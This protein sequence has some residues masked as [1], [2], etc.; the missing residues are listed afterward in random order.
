MGGI[1]VSAGNGRQTPASQQFAHAH[2]MTH[3]RY[4]LALALSGYEYEGGV[5]AVA[6]YRTQTMTDKP[7]HW[8]PL[9]SSTLAQVLISVITEFRCEHT[10]VCCSW[11]K[12][13]TATVTTTLIHTTGD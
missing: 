4:E 5:V 9:S 6:Y 1:H 8:V 7:S 2:S 3:A 11:R 10:Q 12:M 13:A